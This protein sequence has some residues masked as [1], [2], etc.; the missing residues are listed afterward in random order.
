MEDTGLVAFDLHRLRAD[1]KN[2][3]TFNDR[4]LVGQALGFEP[5]D[6]T[7]IRRHQE[8]L[9]RRSFLMDRERIAALILNGRNSDNRSFTGK[10]KSLQYRTDGESI[11]K[12][13]CVVSMQVTYRPQAKHIIRSIDVQVSIRDDFDSVEEPEVSTHVWD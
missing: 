6:T 4:F 2:R 11:V 8:R 1:C 9:I 12:Q 3:I 5:A 10:F 7:D 13:N